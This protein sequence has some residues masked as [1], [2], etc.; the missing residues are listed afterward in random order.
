MQVTI[1]NLRFSY[2]DE[3]VLDIHQLQFQS[4]KVYGIVGPNGSGKSTFFNCFAGQ[5]KHNATLTFSPLPR[6]SIGYFETENYFYPRITALEYLHFFIQKNQSEN[7]ETI[8]KLLELP[9]NELVDDFSSGMKKKLA[10]LGFL[11]LNKQVLLL[12]EPFNALDVDAVN[13]VGELLINEKKADKIILVSSHIP[14]SLTTICDEILLLENGQFNQR[15]TPEN[16]SE[17]TKHLNHRT[18]ATSQKASELINTMVR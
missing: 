18:A 1:D 16:Y 10:L 14:A 2:G 12:D 6:Y 9:L 11:L 5:L 7:I 8:A 3:P 4:G 13:I 15:F 17:L